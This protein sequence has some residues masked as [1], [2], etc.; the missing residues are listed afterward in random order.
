MKLFLRALVFFILISC[1]LII[2]NEQVIKQAK[3][4]LINNK[5]KILEIIHIADTMNI[6]HTYFDL[7]Y[8]PKLQKVIV[9]GRDTP[10]VQ[11]I[12]STVTAKKITEL[13]SGFVATVMVRNE[14]YYFSFK[15]WNSDVASKRYKI[16]FYKGKNEL[17]GKFKNFEI[18]KGDSIPKSDKWAYFYNDTVVI[19][20]KGN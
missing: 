7:E 11:P 4:D 19:Y 10:W 12:Y 13:M 17:K 3:S 20:R 1:S 16:G 9:A 18:C 5:E 14:G 8:L 15:S 6:N 2:S